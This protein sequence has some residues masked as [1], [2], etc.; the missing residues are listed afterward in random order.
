MADEESA[1]R[2]LAELVV[3]YLPT[4]IVYEPARLGDVPP[5]RVSAGRAHRVLGWV[6]EIRFR[7][8][9]VALIAWHQEEER[10]L[11]RSD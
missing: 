6:P 9:L 3:E 8:G 7:D 11:Q 5:A 1:I 2:Q 10:P 4:E